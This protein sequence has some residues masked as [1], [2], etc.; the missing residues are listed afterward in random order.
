MY[1]HFACVYVYVPCACLQMGTSHYV[2]AGNR[3]WVSQEH[4]VLLTTTPS[5][6]LLLSFLFPL[7]WVLNPR[8]C[9]RCACTYRSSYIPRPC[10]LSC[11]GGGPPP[12]L[13]VRGVPEIPKTIQVLV[14]ALVA[15]SFLV[16]FKAHSP[17]GP[18]CLVQAG[19]L[20]GPRSEPKGT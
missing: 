14:T 8:P 11:R 6:C 18:E 4:Q 12:T 17:R 9:A 3:N 20:T 7:H 10:S 19:G 16:G 2:R 13:L 15:H 1:E 5:P